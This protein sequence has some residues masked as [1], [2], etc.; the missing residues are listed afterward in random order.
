MKKQ[1]FIL[2]TVLL[3]LV[4]CGQETQKPVEEK[5]EPTEVSADE[6][7]DEQEDKVLTEIGQKNT[8][9]G[10]TVELM[11]IK[12]VNETI[13]LDPIKLTID[14]IKILRM[15]DIKDKGMKD[16]ISQFTDSDTFDTIQIMYS[17]ENTIDETVDFYWP[18]EYIVLDTGEQLDVN[19]NDLMIDNNNGGT[20]YGKVTQ[21]T[22]ISVLINN[23]KAE[24]IKS[25]KLIFGNVWGED[26]K[27]YQDGA[28]KTYELD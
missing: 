2:L 10:M 5:K 19:Y 25:V 15:S 6:P 12:D 21:H 26:N 9:D 23:S 11:E 22:G 17:I 7:I 1:L 16:Y 4:A 3:T 20:L 24:D 27:T 28:E 18:I 8:S 13:D 14:D